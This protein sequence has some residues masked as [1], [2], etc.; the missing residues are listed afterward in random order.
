MLTPDALMK[1]TALTVIFFAFAEK[2]AVAAGRLSWCYTAFLIH[3]R[4]HKKMSKLAAVATIL[5]SIFFAPVSN[6]ASVLEELAAANKAFEK[7][8]MEGDVDYLVNDYTDDGCIIAPMAG[9]TCG[10]ESIRAFWESVISTNPKN[11]EIITEKAGGVEDLAFATGQLVITDA[12]STVQ[13]N[14]FTLVFR[15]IGGLWKLRVDSWNPQ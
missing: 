3:S 15:K 12:E 6:A 7:A 10:R 5:I 4:G 1:R 14:R 13:K 2:L 11:V 9:E 8:L